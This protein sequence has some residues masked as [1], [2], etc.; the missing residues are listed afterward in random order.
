MQ[1]LYLPMKR[2]FLLI[3]C[4]IP[5]FSSFAQTRHYKIN[6]DI[7]AE[8][9]M[10]RPD[11][12]RLFDA[13]NYDFT[14]EEVYFKDVFADAGRV[15]PESVKLKNL[16]YSPVD[17]GTIDKMGLK[18]KKRAFM[19]SMH[20]SR[21]KNLFVTTLQIN[22]LI[23]KDGIYYKL[24][25][26]DIEFAYQYAREKSPFKR[27][28]YDSKWATGEWY[29]FKI[30]KSG[31]YK[32]DK[33]FF[34]SLGIKTEEID[35]AE[36]KIMGNGCRL[37]PLANE[38]P[39]PEDI[40][41]VA[42]RFYGDGNGK[43]DDNEYFL[44]YAQGPEWSEENDTNLNIY[45]D[46]FYYFV[47]TGAGTG[48]RM[49]PYIEPGGNIENTYT[50]YLSYRF[51]EKDETNFTRMGRKFYEKPFPSSDYI[52]EIEFDFPGLITSKPVSFVVKGATDYKGTTAFK[53]DLNGEYAGQANL[54]FGGNIQVGDENAVYG[55]RTVSQEKIHI[56]VSFV[57]YGHFDAKFY[58][59]YVNVS[60][61]VG[62]KGYG[63]QFVFYHPQAWT[64]Q[65][66]GEYRFQ[67]AENIK[68]VWDITDIYQAAFYENTS[69]SFSLKFL[70][71]QKKKF[72]AVDTEDLYI[73]EIPEESKLENQNLHREVFEPDGVYGDPEMLII[74]PAFL[75]HKAV[76]LAEMHRKNNQRVFVA[77]LEKIYN[78]FGTGSQD[79]A[80]IRNFIRY[81][82]WN[83]SSSSSRLKYVLMFGDASVDY[84]GL[85]AEYEL[86]NGENS[87]IVPIYQALNDFSLVYSYCSD[88]F[89]ALMDQNEGRMFVYEQP[90][91]AMGRF[92][93][94]T[95]EEAET[96]I[97]KYRVYF[98]EDSMRPWRTDITL[99]SDDW[100]KSSDNF[101]VNVEQKIA[102]GL[103]QYHPEFNV[104]KLYMDAYVQEQT[105]GGPRYPQAKRD[106]L[107][108]FEKGSLVIAY[109]GHGNEQVLT[110]ERMLEMNDVMEM[111]NLNKLPL[112]TTLTCEFGR[113]DN[114]T[115]ETT[116]EHMLW[117]NQGGALSL[118]TTVREIWISS[119]DGMNSAF[120]E[121]LFGLNSLSNGQI[122]YNPAEA[123][124]MTKILNH[125]SVKFALAYLGDPAFELAIPRPK[126]VLTKIN[127]K[128]TDTLRALQK[129]KIEGEVQDE[130]GQILTG[131]QGK[132]YPRVF[133]KYI[134]TQTLNN[135]NQ[136]EIVYFEKLGRK[137]FTGKTMA[138]NGKFAF[139]FV[140]PRDIAIAYDKGR[141]SFYGQNT[142]IEKNG[143][144][145]S[146]TIGGVDANAEKDDKP[147]VIKA[148]LN[149]TEFANGDITDPNPYL[150]L[151]LEDDH[152]INTI[153][154][155]GHDLMAIL[156][157]NTDEAIILNDY[158]EADTDTYKKGKVKYRL[159]NLEPGWH[160]LKIKAWD[161][162]NNP[163]ETELSFRVVS[164]EKLELDKV[165]NYPNPFINYTEFWFTHNHPF[166]ELDVMVQVYTITGKL[167]WSHRES[168]Y[169]TGFL[170]RDIHWDGNDNFGNKLAKG[171]YI[172]KLSVRT[173]SG[174]TAKKTE[175]LVIL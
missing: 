57:D 45:T 95:E 113:F 134:A 116:A 4:L 42:V 13:Q 26:F 106:L 55:S 147:P 125:Y 32:L 139:E 12:V 47:Q 65:G 66:T 56:A 164:A 72:I 173:S 16:K 63:K 83:A 142:E 100:D 166:E 124:R 43:F 141:L 126:I 76:E 84:K 23:K 54:S 114:P 118:V 102:A 71:G 136:G 171:V 48:K 27:Q 168:I 109:I 119:A 167:V 7:P 146:I 122:Q 87:N 110:H 135:D 149:T 150:L 59:N 105:P 29:R 41:E 38:V 52:K 108:L 82:Y 14:G 151:Y 128:A 163:A 64:S 77:D 2:I 49:L 144:N 17:A 73:P 53:V 97:N 92:I 96:L 165:L 131:F 81:V 11:A 111:R 175:K 112:F 62:L 133:D 74:T 21:A 20:T 132:I 35:P 137:I 30:S 18:I 153:G 143:Y 34:T 90:D 44:F 37:M 123:L 3:V 10:G 140:V 158:Y 130:N 15:N 169:T 85:L 51:Y 93:L 50:D 160:N 99:W 9:E 88:D 161:V 129:V 159:L 148:Y 46:D 117:N 61:Y 39:F 103:K 170:S 107:N 120:Y 145:E 94:R 89:F 6:W 115:E 101:V 138:R 86:S 91:I 60:A 98:S 24:D 1:R 33:D 172:Y 36:I 104:Y 80:A 79:I 121:N 8:K 155:V 28:I 67:Q 70:Q 69:A 40:M 75:H 58:L 127:D 22:P 5:V 157:E 78:E 162:Y 19:A 31:V 174:K 25:A 152:G 156:D 154:G 68:E